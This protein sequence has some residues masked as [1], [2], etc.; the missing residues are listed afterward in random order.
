[1]IFDLY[2]AHPAF[3]RSAGRVSLSANSGGRL[4]VRVFECFDVT[5]VPPGAPV[6]GTLEFHVDLHTSRAAADPAAE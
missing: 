6:D 5:G 2:T 1:V 3:D 4:R